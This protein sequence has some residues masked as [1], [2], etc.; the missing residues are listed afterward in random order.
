MTRGKFLDEL[1]AAGC[2]VRHSRIEYLIAARLL[3]PHK[4]ASGR[5][6]YSTDDLQKVLAVESARAKSATRSQPA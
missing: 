6:S 3:T 2:A 1:A 5:Y 4:D